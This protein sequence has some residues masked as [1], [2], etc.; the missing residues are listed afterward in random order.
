MKT[1]G[2]F[3]ENSKTFSD[4]LFPRRFVAVLLS[5]V[6]CFVLLPN[7]AH[8]QRP[9]YGKMSSMVRRLAMENKHFPA[10]RAGRP[11]Q[12]TAF[13]RI[14]GDA[15][16]I[17]SRGNCQLLARFGNIYIAAVP[18]DKLGRLSRD[19]HVSRIEARRGVQALL[20]SVPSQ[21]N[22]LSAYEG[23]FPLSQA[24]TGKGIVVGI[25]DVGFDLT[26]PTFY[27]STATNY[28]IKALWDQLS[29]D[30]VGSNM[31]VGRDYTTTSE[32]LSLKH[33]RDG[34]TQSHGTHTAGI[35][36]GGGYNSEYRGLAFES[37]ICLVNNA[38]TDD[39]VYIGEMD[40]YKYTSAT[41]ALGFKY[42]FDYARSE[43][44]PC[45]ISF[46]EGSH[47][48]FHG[49]DA[50][51]YETLDS[52]CGPGRI[53]VA[54]AGNEGLRKT[55]FDK[56]KGVLSKGC[57]LADTKGVISFTVTSADVFAMRFV[58]YGEQN[59]TLMLS[60]DRI[61]SA[62]DFGFVDTLTIQGRQI[63]FESV[64]YPSVYDAGQ[65]VY[66][67]MIKSADNADNG[68]PLSLEVVG[69][70]AFV[71]FFAGIGGLFSDQ[72]NPLLDAGERSH[73]VHSPSSAPGVISVGATSYR[74]GFVNFEGVHHSFD[75]GTDGKRAGYSSVGPTVDG[76]IKPDVMAP[77]TNVVSAY[78]SYYIEHNPNAGDTQSDVSR[79][80]FNGRTY[81]WNSNAGTSMS[82]PVVG[83]AVALWLQAKP[84]LTREEVMDVFA[85]TCRHYDS[86][87]TYPNNHYGYGEIDVYR[88]LLYLL[89]LDGIEE[90]SDSQPEK[91]SFLLSSQGKELRILLHSAAT[92]PFSVSVFDLSGRKRMTTRFESGKDSYR[93]DLSSLPQG[94][95]AVQLES[96]ETGFE[97]STLIRK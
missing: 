68:F 36:S 31:Y 76:R 57:F 46:S 7:D 49:D 25:Q 95:Y 67:V 35:A 44:K 70:D 5:V 10:T 94:V 38:V 51:Y 20:D 69:R 1:F 29:A 39:T 72:L 19:P 32:L 11:Q 86:D 30:T 71:A 2:L 89:G 21:V 63:V 3:Y 16:G 92:R 9:D 84:D 22:A 59:D 93:F 13:L 47:Q 37:D 41:D 27:D 15:E 90:L 23:T 4:E 96:V 43:G 56:P 83:G 33:S 54:S 18:V 40:R 73:S 8:C 78:S 61:I 97:G 52:L 12:V 48:D 82:S 81:S 66:D 50:L 14:N 60:T 6:I 26:H 65:T 58:G 64:A 24:F 75:M 53:I 85:H 55:Y 42:I 88:G 34:L 62:G 28:R 87:L 17:L 74:T 77:G 45:V 79:F 80:N 91:A